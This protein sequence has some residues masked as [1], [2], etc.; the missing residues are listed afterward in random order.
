MKSLD[1]SSSPCVLAVASANNRCWYPLPVPYQ[2]RAAE[3]K[4]D[5]VFHLCFSTWNHMAANP[6]RSSG[7]A[8][9]TSASDRLVDPPTCFYFIK[10][11]LDAL[12][13]FA[14]KIHV[15]LSHR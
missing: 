2:R 12:A 15:P 4:S 3:R 5:H 8:W 11:S 13:P 14:S 6:F 9:K 1:N 10:K 7:R